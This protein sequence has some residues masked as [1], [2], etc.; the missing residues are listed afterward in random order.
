MIKNYN[1]WL[2]LESKLTAKMPNPMKKWIQNQLGPNW[3]HELIDLTNAIVKAYRELDLDLLDSEK[4]GPQLIN[5]KMI[6]ASELNSR[7]LETINQ[8]WDKMSDWAKED[9]FDDY[10]HWFK[11]SKKERPYYKQ[12]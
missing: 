9:I 12:K 2:I 3:S 8:I 10:E 6:P 5:M 7:S 11:V 4:K 1:D